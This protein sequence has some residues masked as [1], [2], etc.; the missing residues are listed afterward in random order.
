MKFILSICLL[1]VSVAAFANEK[2]NYV[3]PQLYVYPNA[4]E[5]RIWN[6][7]PRDLRC[8]GTI[9]LFTRSGRYVTHYYN[10]YIYRGMQDFRR[11]PNFNYND[12]YMN[13][14]H[15]IYCTAY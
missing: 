10:A 9:N 12:P 6:T 13:G 1:L 14:H 2:V 3:Y 11:F 4:A 7:T 5:V 15:S 8:S